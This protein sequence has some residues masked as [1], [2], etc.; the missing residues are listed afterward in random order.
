[1]NEFERE[2]RVI[3]TA[4]ISSIDR[5]ARSVDQYAKLLSVLDHSVYD[6]LKA[7][8][9]AEWQRCE[10]FRRQKIN[11]FMRLIEK[12]HANRRI[13]RDQLRLRAAAIAVHVVVARR[14][15]VPRAEQSYVCRG[16]RNIP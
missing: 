10:D 12:M 5:I 15:R 16:D 14:F 13:S 2:E 4:E 8:Y 6:D 7:N 1:M 3:Q 9:I 11:V